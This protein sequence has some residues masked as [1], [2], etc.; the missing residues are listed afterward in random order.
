MHSY[1][2]GPYYLYTKNDYWI[3]E[4]QKLLNQ[5]FP[6]RT[7]KAID[8][9]K[10]MD[11]YPDVDAPTF[12]VNGIHLH[13]GNIATTHM[14]SMTAPRGTQWYTLDGSD[15]RVPGKVRSP[16]HLSPDALRYTGP[17]TL[18]HSAHVKAR[19]LNG[20]TW[21]ALNEAVFAVGPVAENLRITEIMYHPKDRANINE[22]NEEFV[23]LK[24]IGSESINL[25]LVRFTDGIDFTFPN[26]ELAP[27]EYVLV[28]QDQSSFEARY[29][30]DLNIA[31]QYSGSLSNAGEAITLEDAV[32]QIILDFSYKDGW[33]SLTDGDG[34][35]LTII[36]PANPDLDSWNDK[37]SWRASAYATG[38]PGQDDSGIIPNPGSVVINEILAHAH[39]EAPDWIELHNTTDKTIDISGWFLSDS[40]GN[41]FKYQIPN[42]TTINPYGYIVFYQDLHF[43]NSSVSYEPFAL[44]ENGEDVYL[45]SAHNG[46]LTGYRTVED[47]GASLTGVSFGRYYKAST[48]NYNFVA[49]ATSTE[50]SANSYPMV[51][52]VVISEIMYNPDWPVG[53]SYTNEQYEYIELQNISAEPVTLY[54]YATS[55]P[56]KFTDGVEFTFPSDVP[57]SIPAGGHVLIVKKP[58]A[59]SWRYPNVSADIIVGSYDGSLSNAGE[60]L[61]LSMPGDVDIEGKRYYIRID[62]VDYSDGSHPEDT[63]GS[64]D[65]WPIEA[66]GYGLSLTRK[67]PTNYANDP[68]NW[69]ASAPSPGQ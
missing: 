29:G 46:V 69:T 5:Y 9:F 50:G 4:K 20:S 27:G 42:G 53:G 45:S 14:F 39:A 13:G 62:R 3:P 19:V 38:S 11:L 68:E 22:P 47:F 8:Q 30:L 43:G 51:G 60:R 7:A 61:E 58:E 2:S 31:G 44:S 16:A 28:V 15:P 1:S 64:V 26:V 23:E 17:I 6:Y 24:N 66:D 10:A 56:W 57:V 67:V 49:M 35:S 37:D 36:D 25:N 33:R 32:G 18:P 59:F 21:S 55:E 52:P 40:K 12:Q 63:P 54:D 48:D 34:F 65:L 41:L